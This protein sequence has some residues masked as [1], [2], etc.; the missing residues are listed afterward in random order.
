MSQNTP[1]DLQELQEQA[2]RCVND[3]TFTLN[4]L[5]GDRHRLAYYV[6]RIER[7]QRIFIQIESILTRE[8]VENLINSLRHLR[9]QLIEAMEYTSENGIEYIQTIKIIRTNGRPRYQISKNIIISLAEHRFSWQQISN[10][11]GI[12]ISTL[13]RRRKEL[14]ISD[15]INKYSTISDDELDTIMRVIKHEQPYAGELI[16]SGLLISL[17]YKIQRQRIRESIHRV[18]PIGPAIRWSNFVQRQPYTVAGPNSLW[19]NDGTH[20]LIRWKFVIHAFIDGYSRVVTGIKCNTNNRAVSVLDLFNEAITEWGIPHRCRG[21]HG[22][23]NVQVAEW[24][25]NYR[26]INRGSYIFGKSIHNQRI[27]RLWRDVYRLILRIYY[28]I[29]N[30]L[31]REYGLDPNNDIH[32][33][34]LHYVY[35]PIINRALMIFKNQWNEHP[36]STEYN[37]SPKQLFF[38]GMILHGIRGITEEIPLAANEITINENEFG[39]DW[40]G[41]VS[42]HN[43]NENYEFSNISCP[44]NN[45]QYSELQSIVLPLERSDNYGIETYLHALSVVQFLLSENLN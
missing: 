6:E 12:S 2:M 11:L 23:E 28:D 20:S 10:L 17:G 26:G 19:H 3:A 45:E 36:I 7:L 27:E 38:S 33:W 5:R 40:S 29:F 35:E 13:N 41:P 24:M 32:L 18:D 4:N 8:Y 34:C 43:D 37:Q 44:L 9:N 22:G 1:N 21:D 42:N 16:I 39:I 14:N 31:E 30:F 25:I 15:E